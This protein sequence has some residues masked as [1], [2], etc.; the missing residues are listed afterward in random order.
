M[1][2]IDRP[3]SP[4]KLV[5]SSTID[6]LNQFSSHWGNRPES[7]VAVHTPHKGPS[8]LEIIRRKQAALRR[9]RDPE[10][11]NNHWSL[12][13][14]RAS[15]HYPIKQF[16]LGHVRGLPQKRAT[17]SLSVSGQPEMRQIDPFRG[18]LI[19]LSDEDAQESDRRRLLTRS[20]THDTLD[21]ID[22]AF[23]SAERLE[24]PPSQRGSGALGQE[25]MTAEEYLRETA[26]SPE[27]DRN[28]WCT[29]QDY[30]FETRFDKATTPTTEWDAELDDLRD[31]AER[32][33]P[34]CVV[35]GHFHAADTDWER[36]QLLGISGSQSQDEL[37][38]D[39]EHL[40]RA[41]HEARYGSG[42]DNAL[43]EIHDRASP[44]SDLS[45]REKA[46]DEF[47]MLDPEQSEILRRKATMGDEQEAVEQ[48]HGYKEA[49]SHWQGSDEDIEDFISVG[50]EKTPSA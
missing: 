42:D 4:L 28:E 43:G 17:E 21:S 29:A 39:I 10:K 22:A 12:N 49:L 8:K 30:L 33:R 50:E 3:K 36:E 7:S 48:E 47:E 23:S 5:K 9:R 15:E 45:G 2:N 14:R 31:R 24:T 40:M 18:H 27:E 34:S 11:P 44:H 32:E 6:S 46:V 38:E 20:F 35:P 25:L 37:D 26:C 1:R 16:R 41:K 19:H 13:A